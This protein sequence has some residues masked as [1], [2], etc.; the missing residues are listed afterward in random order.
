[1]RTLHALVL[2]GT[3]LSTSLAV[4]APEFRAIDFSGYY[5]ALNADPPTYAQLRSDLPDRLNLLARAPDGSYCSASTSA[6][7]TVTDFWSIDPQT[8]DFSLLTTI[9]LDNRNVRGMA[10]DTSGRLFVTT[11]ENGLA[12]GHRLE[13]IDLVNGTTRVIGNV[14]GYGQGLA[15]SPT[16]RELYAIGVVTVPFGSYVLS[17]VDLETA[18]AT[19]IHTDLG[20]FTQSVEFTP[21]GRLF[22]TGDDVLAELDPV[23]GTVIGDAFTFPESRQM[24]GLAYIPEPATVLPLAALLAW[25]CRRR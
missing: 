14:S 2:V 22:A 3:C 15:F 12:G 20:S 9:D 11:V 13:E 7:S 24:R 17:K 1:M 23:S 4:A 8:G 25:G 19:V 21:D 18:H 16:T 5:Y 10:Y 6:D